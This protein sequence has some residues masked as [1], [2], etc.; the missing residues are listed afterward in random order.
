[1]ELMW[2]ETADMATFLDDLPDADWETASLCAGWNI[3]AV[4]SHM[5]L[6]H[7]TPMPRML[8]TV[9][10]YGFNVSK[11]S[12]DMSSRYAAEH[13][14][15]ELRAEW[16]E[17]VSQRM[18]KGIA[19]VIPTKEGFFDHFVHHQD[20]RRPVGRSRSIPERRLVAALDAMPTIGGFVGSGKRAKGLRWTATDVGWTWGDGP[21]VTG[22]AEALILVASGRGVALDELSGDGVATLRSRL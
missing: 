21:E 12:A 13:S 20:M 11:A 6:G 14:A 8:A 17:V 5:L 15:G 9:A 4:M 18:R 10:R 7:T 19:K 22:N 16:H 1:M 3:K 2:E